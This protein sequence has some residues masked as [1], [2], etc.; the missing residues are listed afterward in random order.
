MELKKPPSIPK[1]GSGKIAL[2]GYVDK[3]ND[4]VTALYNLPGSGG[5]G[6]FTESH[7]IPS[8]VVVSSNA[9]GGGQYNINIGV[10]Q[11]ASGQPSGDLDLTQISNFTDH[12]MPG[13]LV[14]QA[15]NLLNTHRVS[16]TT[17][18]LAWPTGQN[19]QDD[20]PKPIYI[21]NYTHYISDIRWNMTTHCIEG[22]YS[23]GVNVPDDQWVCKV[24]F[25]S[26]E[27]AVA[28]ATEMDFVT[29]QA[30]YSATFRGV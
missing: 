14:N 3:I 10:W 17:P 29:S 2:T 4:A 7:A 30:A 28:A 6:D 1:K 21:A 18:L 15:E 12:V 5:V 16:I 24:Q 13:L 27:G 8:P 22:T 25:D 23:Q 26:C 9:S 19:T 20:P 11:T